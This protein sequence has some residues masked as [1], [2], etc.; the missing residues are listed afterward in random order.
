MG[1]TQ[2]TNHRMQGLLNC[3]EVYISTV[4][5]DFI[6]SE[7]EDMNV[8]RMEHGTHHKFQFVQVQTLVAHPEEQ[9]RRVFGHN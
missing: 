9:I 7:K 4:M 5:K 3:L 2:N 1:R 6:W 8:L